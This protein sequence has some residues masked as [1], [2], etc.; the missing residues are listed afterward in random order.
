MTY[1]PDAITFSPEPSAHISESWIL[2][3]ISEIIPTG[4]NSVYTS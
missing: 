1:Q 2:I 4:F 3:C